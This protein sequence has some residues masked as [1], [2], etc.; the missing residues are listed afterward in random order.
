MHIL[1]E[2]LHVAVI[3]VWQCLQNNGEKC[4]KKSQN[5]Q[6]VLRTNSVAITHSRGKLY[7]L[8][9]ASIITHSMR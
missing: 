3:Q 1:G 7:S 2:V 4:L 6:K 8:E 5:T 9:P